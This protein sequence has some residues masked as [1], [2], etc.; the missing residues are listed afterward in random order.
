MRVG[1]QLPEVERVV[2]WPEIERMARSIE[3]LGFD[4]IWVGDH[5]LYD[6]GGRRVG[7]W[8]AWTQLAA[9]AAVTHRVEIGP[10]VAALPFHQPAILAK[11][12]A[13]VDEVSQGRLI[14]G[15]GAGWN[16]YEFD[17]FGIAYGRRVAG[18]V[19]G[20]EIVRRLLAGETVTHRGE[21]HTVEACVLLPP[22][23]RPGGP[24][25]MIGSNGPRMLA[26][27]L[28]HVAA[29]NTWFEDFGNDP[30]RLPD[31]LA[32]IEAACEAVGRDP[33]T[34]ERSAAFM[35]SFGETP[36]RRGVVAAG[37]T[38]T[39][40]AMADALHRLERAGIDHVQLVL[41][42]ITDTTIE[43][44]GEVLAILRHR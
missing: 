12:A 20:F 41:D 33:A 31:L 22:A 14:L 7:P 43:Q 24:P 2:R 37:C 16:R 23:A 4:S 32:R 1:V 25:L 18:F 39:P 30:D 9:I 11:M 27:T 6:V 21:H 13:S 34:L 36:T 44:A 19:E 26:A 5:L 8:E 10:L 17:A 42:P 15:L 38:G 40:A 28:P 29:W 3:A 35:L